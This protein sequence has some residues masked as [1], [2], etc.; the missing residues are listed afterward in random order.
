MEKTFTVAGTDPA[1]LLYDWTSE[2]LATFEIERL[3]LR[4]FA[5]AV[6]DVGLRATARGER[7]DPDRHRLDHEVKAVTQ[8]LLDVRRRPDGWEAEFIVDV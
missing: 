2:L 1:W 6:D 7:F 3:L 4:D 5:V 8:H